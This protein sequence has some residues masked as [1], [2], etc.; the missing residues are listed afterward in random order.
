MTL[1]EVFIRRPVATILLTIGIAGYQGGKMAELEALDYLFVA[2]SSSV[3]RIQ[4]A[5]TT[6]YHVLWELCQ[7]EVQRGS[8]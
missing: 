5:Q 3:H 7:A 1:P 4:E 2:P 8:S 6:M